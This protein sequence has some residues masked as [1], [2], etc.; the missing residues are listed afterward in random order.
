MRPGQQSPGIFGIGAGESIQ[1]VGFNEAGA[2]K[3]R[4]CLPI[5]EFL[6]RGGR[7]NEAGATKPRNSGVTVAPNWRAAGFN[8]AG[9]TKPRN[10]AR[11]TSSTRIPC[12]QGFNEAGATKPRNSLGT[13]ER[14]R[15]LMGLQ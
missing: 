1:S 12:W 7:F 6:F 14:E 4:N 3:P 15:L 5:E 8:E 2:T 10:L 9:A 13:V 11:V